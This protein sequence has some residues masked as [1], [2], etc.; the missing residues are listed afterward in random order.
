MPFTPKVGDK[1]KLLDK[2]WEVVD[3]GSVNFYS[4]VMSSRAVSMFFPVS[5]ADKLDWIK[6]VP[7]CSKEFAEAVKEKFMEAWGGGEGDN[8]ES[9][10]KW[11]KEH[12]ED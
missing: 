10:H 9:F 3:I 6:P 5:E 8:C 4:E 7:K 2:E 12:T 11:I 1:F